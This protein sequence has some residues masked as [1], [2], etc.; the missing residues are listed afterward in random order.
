[1]GIWNKIKSFIKAP[2]K[3]S[4]VRDYRE[5]FSFFNTDLATNETIF[6]AVSL[7]SNSMGSL[8]L[9][10]YRNYEVVKPDEHE[11][12]RM[13]EYN[14]YSYM[15]PFTWVRCMETLKDINGNSYAIK[16]YDYMYQPIKMH[17]LKPSFV[18]PVIEKDTKEL[19]YEIRDEN[20]LNYVH[21]SH[22]IHFSHVSIDGH[23]GINPI[24]VLRNT[25]DYDREIKEFSLNQMKNGLKAN[26]VIKLGAK[27]NKDAM[28]EYT[29]MIGRFQKNGILFVDQGKEFQELKNSSF[30]DPKVFDVENITIAR[31]ARVYNIPLHK[32]LAEKQSYSSAEQADLEYIKDTILPLARQYEQELNK[33]L[34]TETQRNEG[35]SFRFNLNGLARA[36]M[37]TRGDFYFK[38]I[39]SAWF[40]PNEIRALEEMP[41]IKGGDQLFVSRDLVPIDKIDLILKGGEG[42]GDRAK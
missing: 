30:I 17:I 21:N 10:L 33:K 8:P 26:I 22:I 20:G 34:L 38:G 32:L 7:L 18:T 37:K 12:A 28:N 35:Y 23:K 27:L 40:T 15:T 14:S 9:K 6:S 39:R 5:G 24:N 2:F 1:M 4:I 41:P 16:E 3:A 25:I 19:W 36:D 31:V 42:N 11:L 29:E 13:I